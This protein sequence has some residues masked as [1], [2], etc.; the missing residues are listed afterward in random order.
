MSKSDNHYGF[1][2]DEYK[3]EFNYFFSISVIHQ[4][5]WVLIQLILVYLW[6][7]LILVK[8][9]YLNPVLEDICAIFDEK[10]S[11]VKKSFFYFFYQNVDLIVIMLFGV[12]Q[13]AAV[14]CLYNQLGSEFSTYFL[15]C[16]IMTLATKERKRVNS[17]MLYR[18]AVI[19]LILYTLLF[20]FIY[21]DGPDWPFILAFI[22][23]FVFMLLDRINERLMNSMYQLLGHISEDESFD[24][25]IHLREKRRRHS[26][27]DL[28]NEGHLDLEEPG[29]ITELKKRDAI[30]SINC[31]KKVEPEKSKTILLQRKWTRITFAVIFAIRAKINSQKE[32]RSKVITEKLRTANNYQFNRQTDLENDESPLGEAPNRILNSKDQSIRQ[33]T[34]N[35]I[36]NK[37]KYTPVKPT[38]DTTDYVNMGNDK[39][40]INQDTPKSN[41][42]IAL[43]KTPLSNQEAENFI[44][45]ELIKQKSSQSMN[46][47]DR[48]TDNQYM[49][50]HKSYDVA[51]TKMKQPKKNA[52]ENFNE[53]CM[54]DGYNEWDKNPN[55]INEEEEDD[56]KPK[57]QMPKGKCERILFIIFF[58]IHI[59][60]Y[61]CLPNI[62]Y[63][64]SL[65]KIQITCIFLFVLQVLFA[66]G[67]YANIMVFARAY[68]I[69]MT[70]CGFVTGLMGNLGYVAYSFKIRNK[71]PDFNFFI[72]AQEFSIFRL[73]F[74][75][76]LVE[77]INYTM[78]H[79]RLD[80][81]T[82]ITAYIYIGLVVSINILAVLYNLCVKGMWHWQTGIVAII[83]YLGIIT[84]MMIY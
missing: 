3:P 42:E 59:I 19:V 37:P 18:D 78:I 68:R 50:E 55:D 22:M 21:L 13:D 71:S 73:S 16:G 82:K 79:S 15:A 26:I 69:K 54:P 40:I 44:H 25:D 74:V 46:N 24:A 36:S 64:P 56:R 57:L 58:P 11:F 23:F 52:G 33:S 65:S 20:F 2:D 10:K 43:S 60:T 80:F 9:S 39:P 30:I 61:Y 1:I 41:E 83:Y 81:N 70:I 72:S 84:V 12:F 28:V 14:D 75:F 38:I 47:F 51:A 6:Y 8:S 27:S 34:R 45:P 7:G 32:A 4:G 49:M 77:I 63:K 29:Q 31:D 48:A 53:D 76:G 17:W 5:G 62:R 66:V 35:F 67:M